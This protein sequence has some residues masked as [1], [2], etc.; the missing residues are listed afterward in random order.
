MFSADEPG[1]YLYHSLDGTNP[2]LHVEMGMLGAM[3]VRP[4]GYDA[5][6]N[7]I[8]YGEGT[9]YDQEFLYLLSEVDPDTHTEMERGHYTH[10]TNSDRFATIYFVNGRVFPDLFQSDFDSLYPHQVVPRARHGPPG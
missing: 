3:I 2:G 8:A 7:R 9:P 5:A 10:F 6:T 4:T 1:T